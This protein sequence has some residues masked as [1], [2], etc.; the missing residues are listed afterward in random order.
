MLSNRTDVHENRTCTD[1]STLTLTLTLTLALTLTLTLT[2]SSRPGNNTLGVLLG[3][4]WYALPD[5]G[6]DGKYDAVLGY[7]TIGSRMLRVLCLVTLSDGQ[8]LRF[9]TGTAG[10]PWRH[11]A[12]ELVAD[13]LFLGETIDKRL[14]TVGWL[15][16]GYDDSGWA[17]ATAPPPLPPP[18]PPPKVPLP[19]PAGQRVDAVESGGDNGSCDCEEYCASDWGSDVKAV[20]PGWVGATS[21]SNYTT[22]AGTL[23]C[24]CVQGSHWCVRQPGEG[25]GA[26]CN[27][28]PG[29]SGKYDKPVPHDYCVPDSTPPPPPPPPQYPERQPRGLMTALLAPP[30]LRHEPRAPA[31]IHR[32][33]SGAF[34]LDFELNQAM[35][36]T[37]RVETDGTAAGTVLRLRHAEQ[38]GTDGAIVVSNDLGG[39]EDRTTY[40]LS[41]AVGVQTFDTTFAYFGARFVEIVSV[42]NPR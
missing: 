27:A 4:G 11:G 22:Q 16:N 23:V 24:V 29:G 40:I 20:R 3:H 10:W 9:G 39:I 18:P 33:P 2:L 26:V 41:D 19:C 7:K 17:V 37:L 15:E 14:A 38:V 36:C 32:A 28:G 34:V 25:C 5:T 30:V 8:R 21:V 12:G 35:Q 31:A 13:H 1:T 42:F 6:D